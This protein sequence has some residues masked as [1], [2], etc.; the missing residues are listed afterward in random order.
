MFARAFPSIPNRKERMDELRCGWPVQG[1]GI[2]SGMSRSAALAGIA[3][4]CRYDEQHIELR[5]V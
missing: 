4:Q 3:E 5:S 2:R 1:G